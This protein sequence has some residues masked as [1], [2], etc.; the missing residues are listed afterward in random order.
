MLNLISRMLLGVFALAAA[1]AVI[2]LAHSNVDRPAVIHRIMLRD[3]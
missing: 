1:I 3:C 2:K